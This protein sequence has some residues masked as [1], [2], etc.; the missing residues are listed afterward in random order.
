MK[1]NEKSLL[2]REDINK[3]LEEVVVRINRCSNVTKGGKILS[4]NA[5]VV[6]GDKN[7]TVGYG[8]GKAREVPSAISKAVKDAKKQLKKVFIKNH[9]I[10]HETFGRYRASKVFMKP[11]LGGTGIKAGFAVR[12]VLELAGVRDILTKC[13][14]NRNPLNIVKATMNCLLSL[15]NKEDIERLRGVS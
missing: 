15:K 4:F 3:N 6:V 7:G 10:P 2:T 11:A 8:F 14:G 13:Y 5:L 9:T 1:V 12:A